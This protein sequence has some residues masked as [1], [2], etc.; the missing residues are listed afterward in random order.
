MRTYLYTLTALLWAAN[1]G[2]A[3][4]IDLSKIDRTIR[5]EPAYQT[6]APKYCLLV[7][8][9][10]AKTR[11]WLV[12]DGDMLY[13][14]RNGN[15]D[16][17]EPGERVTGK[18]SR[19]NVTPA[20]GREQQESVEAF[21]RTFEVGEI[22]EPGRSTKHTQ[23]IFEVEEFTIIPRT[24]PRTTS[25]DVYTS[26]R[27]GGTRPQSAYGAMV[28]G[29]RPQEAPVIHFGGPLRVQPLI[30]GQ[31]FKRGENASDLRVVVGTS[32]LGR[33]TF[34]ALG[35]QEI[36]VEFNP[37]A[38]VEFPGKTPGAQPVRARYTLTKRC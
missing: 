29:D 13:V 33:G 37:I 35:N 19:P 10:E 6:K 22:T 32:G 16:L 38:E 12:Q 17:T 20:V 36:P 31:S 30:E 7:F 11:V 28:L 18:A 9:P 5:K 4:Q 14:D 27:V 8:G 26:L 25:V 3:A 34:A 15:G 23:L 21:K 2:S 1:F 24:G